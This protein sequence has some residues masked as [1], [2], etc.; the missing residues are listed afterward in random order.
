MNKTLLAIRIFFIALCAI[1]SWLVCY[2]VEEW[3]HRRGL[4]AGATLLR[5]SAATYVRE[6]ANQGLLEPA[7]S[8]GPTYNDVLG[9][10]T[11]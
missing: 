11:S 9:A 6:G 4:A 3:D 7:D 8:G 10:C 2:T 5:P 1:A